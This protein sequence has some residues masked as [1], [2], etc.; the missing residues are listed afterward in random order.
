MPLIEIIILIIPHYFNEEM[1]IY[2]MRPSDLYQL[3]HDTTQIPV[4]PGHH[5]NFYSTYPTDVVRPG[6]KA[7]IFSQ[8]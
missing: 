4:I 5:T 8:K 7:V 6:S 1:H 2:R 3:S